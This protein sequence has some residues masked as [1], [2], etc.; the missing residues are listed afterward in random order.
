MKKKPSKKRDDTIAPGQII[1]GKPGEALRHRVYD[2]IAEDLRVL[3]RPLADFHL[4]PKNARKHDEKNIGA[5]AARLREF[6]QRK[7]IVVNRQNMEI[8]AGNGTFLA[9]QQLGWT[10]LAAVLVE[11]D[12]TYSNGFKIADNRTAE[13]AEWDLDILD[14]LLGEIKDS[15]PGLYD[16]LLLDDLRREKEKDDESV[17]IEN[18]K[19]SV[20]VECDNEKHQQELYEQF[21]KEGLQCRLLT[22]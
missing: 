14:S 11:D 10:H 15:S 21:Q 3:A 20:I 18:D 13:M 2:H 19:F 12:P 4:D 9:A 16:D 17:D 7:P 5:I 8:E 6:G 22:F 1:F